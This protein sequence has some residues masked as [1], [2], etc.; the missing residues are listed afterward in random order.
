MSKILERAGLSDAETLRKRASQ[1]IE[2]GAV[3]AGYGGDSE[4]VV[5]LLNTA[6]ATEL[7]CMLRYRRHYYT[8]TGL[9]AESVADEFLAHSNEER[10]HADRIAARI[11]QLRGEPD[12][13]PATLES[14][15]HAEYDD[16]SNLRSMLRANLIAERIAIESYGE[17]IRF[18]G[19]DDPTT[20]RLLEDILAVEEEH[21]DE[22]SGLLERSGK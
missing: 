5:E 9:H 6:L 7:T 22:L 4:R 3:T 2:Q 18:I 8:A 17:L 11:V 19:N 10:E 16:S 12:F 14:R 1:D 15:S 13:R 20:R 21:A